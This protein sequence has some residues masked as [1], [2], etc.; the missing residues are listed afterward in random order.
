M[1]AVLRSNVDDRKKSILAHPLAA[2][3][4]SIFI[5]ADAEATLPFIVESLR[6]EVTTETSPVSTGVEVAWISEIRF[7]FGLAGILISF[8]PASCGRVRSLFETNYLDRRADI[9]RTQKARAPSLSIHCTADSS[10][11]RSRL[12]F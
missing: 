8:T 11:S 9:Q 4:I 10:K 3:D 5:A 6:I 1:Y 12:T 7:L 2:P